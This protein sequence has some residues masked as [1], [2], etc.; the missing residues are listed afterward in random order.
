MG[1]SLKDHRCQKGRLLSKLA[2]ASISIFP[3]LFR[4]GGWWGGSS[5]SRCHQ[6]LT[7]FSGG[8]CPRTHTSLPAIAPSGLRSLVVLPLH[9]TLQ[10]APGGPKT[11]TPGSSKQPDFIASAVPF[12]TGSSLLELCKQACVQSLYQLRVPS[13]NLPTLGCYCFTCVSSKCSLGQALLD[14]WGSP[15][16]GWRL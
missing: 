3:G 6:G 10:A 16:C 9:S 11:S 2:F 4:G 14:R 15:L 7:I 12:P 1:P 8:G 13:P 5:L